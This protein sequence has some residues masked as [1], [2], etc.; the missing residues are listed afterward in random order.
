LWGL[1]ARYTQGAPLAGHVVAPCAR[2]LLYQAHGE[3]GAEE[4]GGERLRETEAA[5]KLEFSR[6]RAGGHT[7]ERAGCWASV[8]SPILHKP[9]QTP[10]AHGASD[11]FRVRLPATNIRLMNLSALQPWFWGWTSYPQGPHEGLKS[12]GHA[13]MKGVIR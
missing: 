12:D 11:P 5:P 8:T 3:G 1:D 13:R 7:G 10:S 2:W 6:L 4:E 9:V